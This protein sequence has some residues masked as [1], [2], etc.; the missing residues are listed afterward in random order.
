MNT[1][2]IDAGEGREVI[3]LAAIYRNELLLGLKQGEMKDS[4]WRVLGGERGMGED[5]Y[6]C[7][8]RELRE[9][10]RNAR[11][12]VEN[13]ELFGAF[14]GKTPNGNIPLLVT[15]YIT[16]VEK[17]LQPNSE[18]QK[19]KLFSYDAIRKEPL[20]SDITRQ[21]AEVLYEK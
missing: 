3:N 18:I 16:R 15:V 19:F 11:K 17:I 21:I 7:L 14:I 13:V 10:T 5:D 1:T 6:A 8:L 2:S 12:L 4:L 9:D 20:V